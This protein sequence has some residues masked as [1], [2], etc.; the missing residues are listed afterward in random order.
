MSI[1]RINE[2]NCIGC[3][4]CVLNCPMDV[5]RMDANAKK[6]VTTYPEDCQ[7]CH[8]CRNLCPAEGAITI[9]PD[10]CVRPVVGWG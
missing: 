9:T 7:L 2:D 6:A 10:R 3:G 8:I 5:L 1:E 4:E